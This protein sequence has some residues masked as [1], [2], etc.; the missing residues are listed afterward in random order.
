M[1]CL[2]ISNNQLKSCGF[3]IAGTAVVCVVISTAGTLFSSMILCGNLAVFYAAS[4]IGHS[5][6]LDQCKFN[7]LVGTGITLYNLALLA[8]AGSLGTV[9]AIAVSIALF[10]IPFFLYARKTSGAQQGKGVGYELPSNPYNF[11]AL[12]VYCETLGEILSQ[13][14]PKAEAASSK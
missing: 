3:H 4:H 5:K 1:S 8:T 9:F 7:L 2:G 12:D 6:K 14:L 10:A 11:K 13:A